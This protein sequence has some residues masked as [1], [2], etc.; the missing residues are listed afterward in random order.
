M[1][2]YTVIINTMI[3]G[4]LT[5]ASNSKI[6]SFSSRETAES[7]LTENGLHRVGMTWVGKNNPLLV[8]CLI[9]FD[10]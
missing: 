9:S 3:D 8:G 4:K 7:F 1:A 10:E 5:K 2:N 6:E